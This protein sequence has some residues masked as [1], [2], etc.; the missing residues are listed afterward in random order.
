MHYH[1][2]THE[3][4]PAFSCPVCKKGFLQ[5][6]TLATHM[7]AI[8]SKGAPMFQCPACNYKAAQKANCLRHFMRAHCPEALN[9][10]TD[11]TGRFTCGVC[12]K[13]CASNPGLTYHVATTTCATISDPQRSEQLAALRSQ[14]SSQMS[15]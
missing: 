10:C 12:K 5:A 9:A 15:A 13:D 2:K 14:V 7:V 4:K 1:L 8:H 3:A 6:Q 11:A